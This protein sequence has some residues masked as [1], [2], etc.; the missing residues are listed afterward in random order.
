MNEKNIKKIPTDDRLPSDTINQNLTARPKDIPESDEIAENAD[1]A[2][3][4]M[5]YGTM[6]LKDAQE[7]GYTDKNGNAVSMSKKS[8]DP[9]PTGAYTD[10][11]AG[12]S[13]AIIPPH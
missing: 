8:T 11:G 6:N 4:S 9:S 13:S 2:S 1:R 5:D 12:R 10:L 7:S 3:T